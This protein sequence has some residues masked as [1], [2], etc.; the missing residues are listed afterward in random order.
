MAM[1]LTAL[2]NRN[3]RTGWYMGKSRRARV[4]ECEAV[5]GSPCVPA[6]SRYYPLQCQVQPAVAL[7]LGNREPIDLNNT[8]TR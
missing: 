5:A 4:G 3:R 2:C 7:V 1:T 6:F 8:H